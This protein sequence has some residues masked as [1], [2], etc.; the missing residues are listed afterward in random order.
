MK[1]SCPRTS[2]Y[3]ASERDYKVVLVQDAVSGLYPQG[4]VETER[5]G[6]LIMES[7]DV[8]ARILS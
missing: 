1:R 6:V 4:L 8:L 7:S 5:I 2:I 3:Q